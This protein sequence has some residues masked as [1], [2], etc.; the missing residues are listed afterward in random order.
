MCPVREY[1][2]EPGWATNL[3]LSE[4]GF[5][6]EGCVF[7][8]PGGVSAGSDDKSP[9]AVWVTPLHDCA[10]RQ[11]IMIKVTPGETVMRLDIAVEGETGSSRLTAS[12]E[13][14]A[15][16]APGREIVNQH[17]EERF[18]EMMRGWAAAIEA[19]LGPQPA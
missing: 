16:S 2:W 11:L 17:T 19:C 13:H 9:E 3:I 14:T 18:A 1:E 8:T 12:Y 10:K 5:V 4:S 6:E 15:L 7:T